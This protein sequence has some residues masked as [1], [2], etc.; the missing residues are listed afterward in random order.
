MVETYD[1]EVDWYFS[2]RQLIVNVMPVVRNL[3]HSNINAVIVGE[4]TLRE[5]QQRHRRGREG[6]GPG[7]NGAKS[8][9]MHSPESGEPRSENRDLGVATCTKGDEPPLPTKLKGHYDSWTV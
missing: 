6:D 8:A 3:E 2:Y 1:I 9:L 5:R 4:R 7:G